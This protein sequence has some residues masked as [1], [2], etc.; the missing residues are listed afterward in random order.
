MH[1]DDKLKELGITLPELPKPLGSYVPFVRSGN[2]ILVSGMLPLKEG[3]LICAGRVGETVSLDQAILAARTAA[4][5]GIAVLKS[6]TASLA[7]VMKCLQVTGY[8]ASAS[9]FS[10]QPKVINGASDLL[11][12][13]FGERGRHTRAAVGVHVLPMNATV[14]ITFMFEVL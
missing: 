12:E 6:A 11:V 5:N 3:K 13:V 1:P 7:Q 9:D 2:L 14:E 4:I 10:D 8:V